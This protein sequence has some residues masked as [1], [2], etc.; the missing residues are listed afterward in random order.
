MFLH[1]EDV[2]F[3]KKYVH[4]LLFNDMIILSKKHKNEELDMV[5][6]PLPIKALEIVRRDSNGK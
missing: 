5:Y 4:V 6:P 2:I 3:Q 1:S